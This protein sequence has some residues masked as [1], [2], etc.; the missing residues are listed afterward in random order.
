MSIPDTIARWKRE[1]TFGTCDTERY[2]ARYF[3]WGSGVPILFVHG[4]T[5]RAKSFVPLISHLAD[6]FRCI[7]YDLPVGVED[8]AAMMAY[9]HADH[10]TDVE[11]ILDH[12]RIERAIIVG[13]SLGSTITLAALHRYP[14]RLP[15]GI[16][17]GGF[18]HRPL[19]WLES[20]FAM[21]GRYF[22]G[23]MQNLPL[24]KQAQQFIDRSAF[25]S[26]PT[27]AW[28]FFQENSGSSRCRAVACR[29]LMLRRLDLRPLLPIIHQPVLMIG[30]ENDRIVPRD[31]EEVVL[32][33]LPNVRRIEF[34]KCGHYPQYVEPLAMA[35]A[36]REFVR[37]QF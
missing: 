1:A 29:A 25:E 32:R 20:G 28:E 16:L 35:Q 15:M 33:G 19:H 17:Q 7:A 27:E 9:R 2:C 6:S 24:Q 37:N 23:R 34:P 8:G 26:A 18:A 5:D 14:E 12:L 36:I 10:V 3:D 31:L 21:F 11:S 22:P 13:S 30:G 4:L